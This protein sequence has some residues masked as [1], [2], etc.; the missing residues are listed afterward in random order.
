[1]LTA[2]EFS[3][4]G[5]SSVNA[6]VAFRQVLTDIGSSEEFFDALISRS[7]GFLRSYR[8]VLVELVDRDIPSDVEWV[9][10]TTSTTITPRIPPD[11]ARMNGR[12]APQPGARQVFRP[13]MT[14]GVIGEWEYGNNSFDNDDEEITIE[15]F[16]GRMGDA[17][18][19]A[20][21]KFVNF[22]TGGG[23]TGTRGPSSSSSGDGHTSSTDS[24]RRNSN[25]E[26]Y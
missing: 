15:E 10:R 22:M 24:G 26:D 23:S 13:S 19:N 6:A 20:F 16:V 1:M 7:E 12:F 3:V 2:R 18:E 11:G 5:E 14:A 25:E 21:G 9:I 4:D 8:S 17:V